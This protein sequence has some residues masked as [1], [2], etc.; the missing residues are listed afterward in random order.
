MKFIKTFFVALAVVFGCFFFSVSVSAEASNTQ[1]P[2]ALVASIE[3][4]KLMKQARDADNPLLII[5]HLEEILSHDENKKHSDFGSSSEEFSK[6][7]KKGCP[8]TIKQIVGDITRSNL[9]KQDPEAIVWLNMDLEEILISC[10][11]TYE[12]AGVDESQIDN[13]LELA[14]ANLLNEARKNYRETGN[15]LYMKQIKRFLRWGGFTD[16]DVNN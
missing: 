12:K 13:R 2:K 3:H 9:V 6:L 5:L 14:Y 10:N 11:L 7:K 4:M 8:I 16:E 1:N 15:Q